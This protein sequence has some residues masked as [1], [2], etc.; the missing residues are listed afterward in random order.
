MKTPIKDNLSL[1]RDS[2]CYSCQNTGVPVRNYITVLINTM[3]YIL[4]ILISSHQL[5]ILHPLFS[6][7]E[8]FLGTLENNGSKSHFLTFHHRQ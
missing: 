1:V 2:N 5:T 4:C 3:I 8:Y 6:L 7:V